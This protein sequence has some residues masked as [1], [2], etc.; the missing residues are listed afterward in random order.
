[1]AISSLPASPPPMPLRG[2]L[3]AAQ[4]KAGTCW[5]DIG[6]CEGGEKG[7]GSMEH[8]RGGRRRGMLSSSLEKKQLYLRRQFKRLDQG[9]L[10]NSVSL[11]L[12]GC[13]T[14]LCVEHNLMDGSPMR[15]FG[16]DTSS[17]NPLKT[18]GSATPTVECKAWDE[19]K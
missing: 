11:S 10:L 8:G 2:Q 4:L 1:M 7:D 6:V 3:R 9:R 12:L 5:A 14:G 18:K 16:R 13:C 15:E 19:V 17:S